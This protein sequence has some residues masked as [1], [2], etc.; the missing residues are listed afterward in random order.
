MSGVSLSQNTITVDSSTKSEDIDL[1]VSPEAGIKYITI[2]VESADNP[3]TNDSI[4]VRVMGTI[5]PIYG[6]QVSTEEEEKT[7]SFGKNA[8]FMLKIQNTGNQNDSYALSVNKNN[9]D[10]SIPSSTGVIRPQSYEII[11]LSLNATSDE[12]A[13]FEIT[14]TSNNKSNAY[15]TQR[16]T[17]QSIGVSGD[18]SKIINSD[19][20]EVTFNLYSISDSYI[21]K[22]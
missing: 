12:D 17:V 22:S 13:W 1:I 20:E 10:G 9:I 3:D 2:N 21:R 19:F 7:V 11:M 14:A 6:V 4:T 18:V 8:T 15:D 5:K 16:L